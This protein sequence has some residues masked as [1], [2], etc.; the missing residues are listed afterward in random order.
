MEQNIQEEL[1]IKTKIAAWLMKI[2]G[3]IGAIIAVPLLW[4]GGFILLIPGLLNFFIGFKIL[5]KK[6]KK[7]LKF[8]I[9]VLSVE[10]VL[11][12]WFHFSYIFSPL[13]DSSAHF[14]TK[15]IFYNSYMSSEGIIM[16]FFP[17]FLIVIPLALLLLDRK[18]FWKVA[19][20]NKTVDSKLILR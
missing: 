3:G 15:D 1:P 7:V 17:L 19:R 16:F 12:I 18:N 14:L 4:Y 8:S 10:T 5:A 6:T 11:F 9:I 2:L 20:Q 13:L